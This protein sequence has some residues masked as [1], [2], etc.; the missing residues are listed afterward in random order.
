MKLI[1]NQTQNKKK[2]GA[3][4]VEYGLLVAG[5]ALTTAAAVSL[6]GHKTN[7]MVGTIASALPSSNQEDVGQVKGGRIIATTDGSAG[8]IGI[9]FQNPQS[10]TDMYGNGADQAI[11]DTQN[12]GN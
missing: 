9:D 12:G 11:D 6:L 7:D 5:V 1:K 4:L 3:A 8:S 10:F 2:R